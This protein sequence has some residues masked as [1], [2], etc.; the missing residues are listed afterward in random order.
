MSECLQE[1]KEFS[2][3]SLSPL[4][5]PCANVSP[6]GLSRIA[7]YGFAD[8]WNV[9]NSPTTS[10]TSSLLPSPRRSLLPELLA[11]LEPESTPNS[12]GRKPRAPMSIKKKRARV[13]LSNMEQ[14]PSTEALK[15]IGSQYGPPLSPTIFSPCPR[16]SEFKVIG[17][18]ELLEPI[19]LL[20]LR[21][22]D[23]SLC[24]GEHLGL[25]RVEEPGMKQD[26][27][28]T[29]RI[30][31]QSFGMDT[32][33]S[34]TLSSMSFVVVS[35]LPISYGGVTGIRLEWKQKEAQ[36]LWFLNEFGLPPMSIQDFGTPS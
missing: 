5:V 7:S 24:S 36:D 16:V 6:P 21:W 29:A 26:W 10:I 20:L 2:G 27:M 1:D 4:P 18:Y 34:E 9:E 19:L 17:P 14:S 28:L 22:N 35:M 31:G 3:C 30:R 13:N 8:S 11:C 12:L 15:L 32:K 33:L 23:K 25:E